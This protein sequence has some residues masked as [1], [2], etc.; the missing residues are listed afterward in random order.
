MNAENEVST[1]GASVNLAEGSI[2]KLLLKLALP[3]TVAQVVNL[4]YNM[5]DRIFIGHIPKTGDTA[6]TG[7]GLCFAILM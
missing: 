7:L 4:L 5:V 3:A 6:L 2:G 1:G